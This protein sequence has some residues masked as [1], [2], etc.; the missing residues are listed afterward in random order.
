MTGA[1]IFGTRIAA[2][3]AAMATRDIDV[4]VIGPSADMFYLLGKRLP[5]T[6]RFNALVI[7]K[8][9]EATVVVPGLQA[10]LVETLPYAATTA[11]WSETEDPLAKTAAIIGD[12][13]RVAVNPHL[14]ARFLLG[15]QTRLPRAGFFD[16]GALT[17]PLRLQ[18]S[19]D[20][21]AFLRDL[22]RRFD[23]IWAEFFAHEKLIGRT[24]NAI[25]RRIGELILAQGFDEVSWVDV[26]SGPN[27]ASPL[28]HGSERR[29]A[30][31]DPVVID[32]AGTKDGYV[33][34]TCRTPIAGEPN[35][36]FR[37][38]YDIVNRAHE[39][40]N[41]A[42]RPGAAAEDV[43]KAAR[44]V[45]AA[46][47]FGPLFTHRTGHGLGID[48]HEEPYI[49]AGNRQTLAPGMV[50][51]DEPGIYVPGRWGCRIEN[52]LVITQ[53]GAE[54]LNAASRNLVEMG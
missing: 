36:E 3:Q 48:A 50:F 40:A 32:F 20:E 17:T 27:G 51:S 41:A 19:A 5:L 33:M 4:T 10:P 16:A 11:V 46:A 18:K 21:T 42:A 54:S 49:V 6:E 38:I 43:D 31:G 44:D 2:I 14:Y 1:D 29:I 25:R 13:H 52:I 47:G 35:P 7:P 24:E 45:I 28:H 23:A 53:S 34:D 12:V 30:P 22:G 8:S 26:G 9:G 15:L 37:T 39:A